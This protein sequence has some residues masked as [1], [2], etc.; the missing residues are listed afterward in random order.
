MIAEETANIATAAQ[1]SQL[2]EQN[3]VRRLKREPPDFALWYVFRKA[4]KDRR[5][6]RRQLCETSSAACA[7]DHFTRA[8][9]L[10]ARPN[11]LLSSVASLL[12]VLYSELMRCHK[13]Q[14]VARERTLKTG[15]GERVQSKNAVTVEVQP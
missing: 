11:Y 2:R 4:K 1:N 13:V 15:S 8:T 9:R 14:Q 3:D 12:L 6:S 5:N 10:G 7:F